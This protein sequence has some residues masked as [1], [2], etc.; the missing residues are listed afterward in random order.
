MVYE[1]LGEVDRGRP[2]ST[3]AA[4]VVGCFI[5]LMDWKLGLCPNCRFFMLY[6]STW[7]SGADFI[8]NMEL[9]ARKGRISIIFHRKQSVEISM[10]LP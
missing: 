1:G 7:V 4:G 3:E 10:F 5:V 6:R 8:K 9:L 2:R